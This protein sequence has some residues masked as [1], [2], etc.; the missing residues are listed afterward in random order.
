MDIMEV[1]GPMLLFIGVVCAAAA[2]YFAVT[3][4]KGKM[5]DRRERAESSRGGHA[6]HSHASGK[7]R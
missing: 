5:R 6:S 2:V 7:R 1:L 3:A 4:V